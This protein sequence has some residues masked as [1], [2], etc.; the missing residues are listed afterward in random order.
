MRV[1]A[2]TGKSGS[3]K[4]KNKNK[5]RN[6]KSHF[7][8]V[9]RD[10]KCAGYDES[11]RDADDGTQRKGGGE[12]KNVS[13]DFSSISFGFYSFFLFF[14]GTKEHRAQF[15]YTK[16]F[17]CALFLSQPVLWA[18]RISFRW[19]MQWLFRVSCVHELHAQKHTQNGS[20]HRA[21]GIHVKYAHVIANG[22]TMRE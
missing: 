6:A 9:S 22:A 8:C 14:A 20:E 4:Q 2:A 10:D 13:N 5:Y 16:L 7:I 17:G 11:A 19:P 15:D 3:E 18:G 1:R 21:D 12:E